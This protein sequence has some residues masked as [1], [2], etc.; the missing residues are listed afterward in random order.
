MQTNELLNPVVLLGISCA[1]C[2]IEKIIDNRYAVEVD[3]K[4]FLH[5]KF[6]PAD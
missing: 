6:Q 3:I 5:V 4:D 2:I 1:A